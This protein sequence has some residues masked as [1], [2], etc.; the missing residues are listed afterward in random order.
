[1]IEWNSQYELG[2]DS[3]D[4][5]HK[6]LVRITGRLSTLLTNAIN[7]QDIY[8]EMVLIINEIKNYTVEHFAYEEKL[9]DAF[10]Y[11]DAEKHKKEHRKLIEDIEKLDLD[12]L[13]QDQIAEGKKIL[14]FL[15]NWVFKHISGSDYLYKDTFKDNGL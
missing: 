3:I 13:D 2:I 1:M 12:V 7:G 5:Q 4:S 14:N 15:I 9:F 8:D 11:K 6:E 10:G